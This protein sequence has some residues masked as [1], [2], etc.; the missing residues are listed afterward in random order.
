MNISFR[1]HSALSLAFGLVAFTGCGEFAEQDMS[2]EY[3]QIM[4]SRAAMSAATECVSARAG[5]SDAWCQAVG[6]ADVYVSGGFC[7]HFEAA[8]A[9]DEAPAA[10]A[11]SAQLEVVEETPVQEIL[12]P[13]DDAAHPF[14]PHWATGVCINDGKA[15]SWERSL[16]ADASVCCE[17]HFS[18]NLEVCL[19]E[20]GAGLNVVEAAED[21]EAEALEGSEG[22]VAEEAEDEGVE[23]AEDEVFEEAEEE[24]VEEAEEEPVEEGEEEVAEEAED[25]VEKEEPL[26]AGQCPMGWIRRYKDCTY[27]PWQNSVRWHCT[28]SLPPANVQSCDAEDADFTRKTCGLDRGAYDATWCENPNPTAPLV[29]GGNICDVPED[30]NSCKGIPAGGR[31]SVNWVCPR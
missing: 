12:T 18:W 1:P 8:D 13:A 25:E 17:K 15:P 24:G 27:E 22:D 10:E 9:V 28:Q 29:C 30:G 14:Y 7:R 21:A 19:V 11:P 16:Y 2:A 26:A 5:I 23:E 31:G 6:C 3:G 20:T 4:T